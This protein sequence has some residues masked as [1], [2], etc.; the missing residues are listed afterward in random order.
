M[1]LNVHH[2]N[3]AIYILLLHKQAKPSFGFAKVASI[4]AKPSFGFAKVASIKHTKCCQMATLG[5]SLIDL[6]KR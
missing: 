4:K 6:E 5:V 2:K 3:F 1:P